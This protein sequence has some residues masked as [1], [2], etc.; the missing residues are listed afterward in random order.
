M[1][2]DTKTVIEQVR[3]LAALLDD[4]DRLALIRAIASLSPAKHQ[5]ESTMFD[6]RSLL[7]VEQDSW[8]AHPS[9]ERRQYAGQYV[10][11]HG[12]QVVDQDKDQRMLYLRVRARYGSTPVLII[13]AD[14]DS[15][16]TYTIRSPHLER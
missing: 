1:L 11:V 14:W 12:G 9:A 15:I 8:F 13:H 10:A 2:P 5:Q 7:S 4:L 3:S 6:A 16:P